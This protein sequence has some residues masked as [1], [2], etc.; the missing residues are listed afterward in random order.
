MMVPIT[1]YGWGYRRMSMSSPG[2]VL[3][4]KSKGRTAE[5]VSEIMRRVGSPDTQPE[6][7]LMHALRKAGLRFETPN[8]PVCQIEL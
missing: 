3:N 7:V 4:K 6:M 5:E 1:A 2:V 8:S